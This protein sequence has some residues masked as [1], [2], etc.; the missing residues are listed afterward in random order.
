MD[1]MNNIIELFLKE[2]ERE[3]H[4]REV[5]K[6]TGR[7]P[8][9][10]SNYLKRYSKKG[11]LKSE[12]K[13]NHLFFRADTENKGFKQLKLSHN[14]S[15]LYGSGLVSYLEENYNYPS[16]IILFGSYAKAENTGKSDIDIL[17]ITP[18][19]REEDLSKF[20]KKLG[21]IQLH[22][23]SNNEIELMKEKNKELLNNLINGITLSGYWELF[24]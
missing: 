8:T 21:S 13:L 1:N 23:H 19:K 22:L 11:I 10:V 15:S 20:E 17:I 4:V 24:K 3:F 2:P 5:S 6:L 18:N 16:A 7:S 14:L 9:T 12:K